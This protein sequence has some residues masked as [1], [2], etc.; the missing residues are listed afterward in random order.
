MLKK[1]NIIVVGAGHAGCEAAAAA[2]K[3]GSSVL[4][5]TMNMMTIAQMSCN[6]AMGG[7]AK[8]QIV[9]EIDALGGLSG[10]ITDRTMIQFRMLNKS[11]GPAMWSPRA[12][13]DRMLFSLEWRKTLENIPNIDFWQDMVTS[14]IID[15]ETVKGVRTILGLEIKSD[16]VILTNGTFLNGIIHI[17]EKS[18]QGGRYGEISSMGIT[19]SLIKIG[20]TS[21]RMKTGTPVRVDGRSL[22]FNKMQEQKGDDAPGKFSFTNTPALKE[23]KS[24]YLTYTNNKVHEILRTGFDKSPLFVGRIK[25]TG[26]RYCPSIEDKI[27]RFSDKTR[28]QLF[29]EPEGR[30]TVEYYVNGFSS[31]LPQEIQYKALKKV[32][33]FEKAKIFRPGYAIEYDYFHPTQ[34]THS[35][36]TKLI[37]HLYFAG[38]INGTTGYEEAACQGLMAG[39]NAHRKIND[40]QEFILK[41][42][43][44]YIGVLIDDLVT[45]G[46]TEPYR[47]F[48]SRAEFR[49]LL[50]QDNADI[51]LTPKGFKIGLVERNRVEA[52]NFK[53][54]AVNEIIGFLKTR[55]VEPDEINE[56]LVNAETPII[57]QKIKIGN[58]LMRPQVN[59]KDLQNSS[60]VFNNFL[61]ELK[62]DGRYEEVLEE[63][64]I[65]FKYEGYIEKEKEIAHKMNRLEDL[66]LPEKF[67]YNKL[68]SLSSEAREKL[69][70]IK[71]ATLG[72]ASRISGVSPADISV[73]LVYL[74]R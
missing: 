29:V 17:G 69:S 44:A 6:P 16:A 62:L 46:T 7:I 32:P 64:E 70:K 41:R 45:K 65:L 27:E 18:F 53:E 63:T 66:T 13:N 22:N 55:N 40:E 72:Q 37:K 9:R 25:G 35:L 58:L 8:G 56:L 19:E 33:G 42:S 48:T 23:Q 4:L 49:M 31:S 74:G 71:P 2:A 60:A 38:Q 15:K 14:V 68:K 52:L 73:L 67:D 57:N 30:N 50:R 20:F 3:S 28:H 47:M 21:G 51:R 36:E 61:N 59:I 39:I 54:K 1:Y 43:E 26:P 11:K 24:C 5:V 10:I 12:Q 34:L